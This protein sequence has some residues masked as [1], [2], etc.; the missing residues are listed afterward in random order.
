[1]KLLMSVEVL[2]GGTES[3][4]P[5]VSYRNKTD[6]YYFPERNLAQSICYGYLV[7]GTSARHSPGSQ[8]ATE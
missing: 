1:M 6:V 2:F 8:K 5:T 3:V 7:M 4:L